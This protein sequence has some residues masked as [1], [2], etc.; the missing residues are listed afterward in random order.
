M[1]VFGSSR[2]H[3]TPLVVLV[4]V[5]GVG[6]S[7][8]AS[9][10]HDAQ[11]MP[12]RLMTPAGLERLPSHEPDRRIAYGN[13][14]TQHGDLRVPVGAGP[15]PVVVTSMLVTRLIICANLRVRTIWI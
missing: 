5:T 10:P 2:F 9:S 6:C 12:R 7:R 8:R 1:L 14:S 4:A 13:D 11:A 15:H 3:W